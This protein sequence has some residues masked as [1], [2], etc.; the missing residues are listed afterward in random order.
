MNK[1]RLKKSLI[2]TELPLN[3]PTSILIELSPEAN[4]VDEHF[5]RLRSTLIK[6]KSPTFRFGTRRPTVFKR[7]G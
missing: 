1:I 4:T 3:K 6:V 5:G 2:K 7:V